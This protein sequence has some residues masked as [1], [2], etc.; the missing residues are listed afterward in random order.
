MKN[1]KRLLAIA[2]ATATVVTAAPGAVFALAADS[3][4]TSAA[5]TT[6]SATSTTKVTYTVDDEEVTAD[7][8]AKKNPALKLNTVTDAGKTAAITVSGT[9]EK[10][11][12]I[13][14]DT[15]V[16]K[17]D[18]KDQTI[19]VTAQKAGKTSIKVTVGKEEFT[20]PVEIADT[21][22]DNVKTQIDGEDSDTVT[23]DQDTST[24][25]NARKT[26][27]IAGTSELGL[28]V[29]YD[30]YTS[31]DDKGLV[32]GNKNDVV[33]L[34]SDG[35]LT[36]GKQDGTV[37][38]KV[39]TN[40]NNGKQMKGAS[41]WVTV[42]V[43]KLPEA[44][45]TFK[46]KSITL[47][48]KDNK[49]ADLTK[50][51]TLPEG[52]KAEYE[53]T[54]NND[55][56]NKNAAVVKDNT[57]TAKQVGNATLKV[58]VK[59]DDKVRYTVKKLPVKVLDEIPAPAKVASD[60]KTAKEIV[61]VKVGKTV[62]IKATT[63]S[64]KITYTSKDKKIATVD[65][66]GKVK[67]VKAGYVVVNIKADATDTMEAGAAKVFVV[68]E[69]AP[70]KPAKKV[71]VAKVSSVKITGRK[72]NSK[73]LKVSWKKL[74]GTGYTYEVQ[75]RTVTVTKVKTGKGK[76]AKIKT[77]TK[78]GKWASKKV[79]SASATISISKT[80]RYQIRVRAAK[81]GKN[82]AWSSTVT[83]IRPNK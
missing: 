16:V 76:K 61:T 66:K 15:S 39:Y 3:A 68:V 50:V 14:E 75:N 10:V 43:A 35:T 48:V 57:L 63:K 27:K 78:Y 34:A 5:A 26:A 44:N 19:T 74:S 52:T 47:D 6:P 17:A 22:S 49:T 13:P 36:A 23:L 2:M 1:V 4:T 29:N 56:E 79:T 30:L 71:T 9:T 59:G 53:I 24:A 31:K 82:G 12:V 32:S 38:V 64:T 62:D 73:S 55:T 45:I 11:Y 58:T 8:D 54:A 37:Y 21:V 25:V 60:L 42:T 40:D 81:S 65:K 70:K 83:S 69:S 80:S 67:G 41:A 33:T 20:V 28:A 72:K 46:Q 51:V 18:E 7:T 77:V